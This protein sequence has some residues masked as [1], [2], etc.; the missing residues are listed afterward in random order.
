[1]FKPLFSIFIPGQPK[2][3]QSFR[4]TRNGRKYQPKEVVEW[5][6]YIKIMAMKELP[7]HF[8]RVDDRPLHVEYRFVYSPPKSMR[9]R[10]RAYMEQG[11]PVYKTTRPDLGDNLRKGLNDAL[12]GVVWGDDSLI[13]SDKGEKV[14]GDEPGIHIEVSEYEYPEE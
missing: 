9:K 4:F 1:M 6:T 2:A 10:D 8:I 7:D 14:Y 13:V 3:V 12:T 11:I 5:K